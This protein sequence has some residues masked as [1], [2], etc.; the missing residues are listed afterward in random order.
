MVQCRLYV[1]KGVHSILTTAMDYDTLGDKSG[2]SC[3][4]TSGME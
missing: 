1:E 2:E 4:Q 3:S